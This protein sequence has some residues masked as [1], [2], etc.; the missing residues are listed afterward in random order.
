MLGWLRHGQK[1]QS[2][3]VHTD[4]WK[5]IFDKAADL[6][7][8]GLVQVL[9]TKGHAT[10]ADVIRGRSSEWER[11]GNGATDKEAGGG[12]DMHPNYPAAEDRADRA[13][14]LVV[15]IAK[16]LARCPVRLVEAG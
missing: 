6:E 9:K 15:F 8:L 12:R 10:R 13:T 7:G 2:Q 14:N 5:L 4:L 1:D 3:N 11:A 16:Y